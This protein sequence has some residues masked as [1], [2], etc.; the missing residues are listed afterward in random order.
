[1]LFAFAVGCIISSPPSSAAALD[2]KDFPSQ[3]AAQANLRADPADPNRLD[4]DKNGIACQVYA[5]PAGS[6]T[7]FNAVRVPTGPATGSPAS[8]V[9]PAAPA[10]QAR[11][12]L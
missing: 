3:A 10:G 8:S 7:D 2:C 6:P 4:A 12:A 9:A 1:M 5:Y 11:T